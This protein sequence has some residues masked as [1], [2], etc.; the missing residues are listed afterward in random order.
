MIKFDCDYLEGCHPDILKMLEKTNFEQT[1]G[2]GCDK[3]CE[4]AKK[5]ILAE[6]GFAGKRGKNVPD[7]HFL[8]GGTQTNTTVIS[9]ILRPHQGVVA[10]VTGHVNVHE[11]GAIESTGHKVLALPMTEN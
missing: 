8:V 5:L 10:A 6:C 1:E 2:Y 7:V 4:K 3:Y 9:A 11:T